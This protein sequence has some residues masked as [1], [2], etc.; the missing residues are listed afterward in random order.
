MPSRKTALNDEFYTET[1]TL[2]GVE[3]TFRELTGAQYE[4]FVK[5]CEGPDGT[6]DLVA[7]LKMMLPA[8]LQSPRLTAEQ[9]LAKPLP[10]YNALVGVVN[11][12]HFR[13]ETGEGEPKADEGGEEKPG[14]DSEPQTS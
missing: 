3:Y 10:V 6:S 11:R 9:I 14:N 1:I 2:R 13:N 7:V 8:S 4:D 5:T 12:M